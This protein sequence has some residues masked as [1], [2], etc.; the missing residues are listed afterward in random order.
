MR[1]PGVPRGWL[2]W[3]ARLPAHVDRSPPD[4]ASTRAARATLVLDAEAVAAAAAKETGENGHEEG[5][6]GGA[7]A[8]HCEWRRPAPC[9]GKGGSTGVEDAEEGR[10]PTLL[11]ESAR[12]LWLADQLLE[13]AE[14]RSPLGGS[15]PPFSREAGVSYYSMQ[16]PTLS[17]TDD[18][19]PVCGIPITEQQP[20]G[21]YIC[22]SMWYYNH[23][24]PV[25]FTFG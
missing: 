3:P 5:L 10:L 20:T 15:L 21:L 9:Y 6:P 17:H 25:T 16:C 12:A 24:R 8:R 11:Q 23:Q 7:V 14:L 2:G 13:E 4:V 18:R 1:R 19:Y 22:I